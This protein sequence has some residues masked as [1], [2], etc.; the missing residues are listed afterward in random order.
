MASHFVWD[1]DKFTNKEKTLQIIDTNGMTKCAS[2][3]VSR[4]WQ[5][6]PALMIKRGEERGGERKRDFFSYRTGHEISHICHSGRQIAEKEKK[7]E[8]WFHNWRLCYSSKLSDYR[9]VTPVHLLVWLFSFPTNWMPSPEPSFSYLPIKT[10]IP[11]PYHSV[12]LEQLQ[13]EQ[14]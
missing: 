4:H 11:S 3:E 8:K 7:W 2:Q 12:L 6:L 13:H 9:N 1:N 14:L 5:T 10:S